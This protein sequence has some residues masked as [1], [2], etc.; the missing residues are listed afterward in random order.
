[1][2]NF[3]FISCYGSYFLS[4]YNAYMKNKDDYTLFL[5]DYILSHQH[6]QADQVKEQACSSKPWFYQPINYK[7]ADKSAGFGVLDDIT[8]Y[9]KKLNLFLNKNFEINIVDKSGISGYSLIDYIDFKL[10]KSVSVA[11]DEYYN[12][13]LN[14]IRLNITTKVCLLLV[15]T[16]GKKYI[17]YIIQ[18][19]LILFI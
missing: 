8:F 11:V 13:I 6:L 12:L 1:M 5:L 10:E 15:T 19:I 17:R 18:I 16:L 2:P 4:I 14:I 9:V 3:V 7:L